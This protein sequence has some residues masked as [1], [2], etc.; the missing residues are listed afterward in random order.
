MSAFLSQLLGRLL[1]CPSGD[2][3]YFPVCCFV[4]S[5]TECLSL[6][7]ISVAASL[8]PPPPSILQV[9]PQLPLMGFVARVQENSKFAASLCY[10]L[11]LDVAF[12]LSG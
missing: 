11:L 9:T 7:L 4:V 10:D 6:F 3:V 2:D 8:A 1:H 5:L 12:V